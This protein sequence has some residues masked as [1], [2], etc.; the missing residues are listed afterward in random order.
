[1]KHHENLPWLTHA[2][3]DAMQP[4]FVLLGNIILNFDNQEFS[5]SGETLPCDNYARLMHLMHD[6]LERL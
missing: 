3:I 4:V 1:M 2:R 6:D 5:K